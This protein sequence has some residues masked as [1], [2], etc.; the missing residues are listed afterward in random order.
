M[1]AGE[2]AFSDRTLDKVLILLEFQNHIGK[3]AEQLIE[4]SS[5]QSYPRF[6]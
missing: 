2:S 3:H 4:N 5:Y 1:S 6:S